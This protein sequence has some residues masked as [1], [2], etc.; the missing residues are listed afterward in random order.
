L[1]PAKVFSH[2]GNTADT[3]AN[4]R[5]NEPGNDNAVAEVIQRDRQTVDAS[6]PA[7]LVAVINWE[8]AVAAAKFGGF[9]DRTAPFPHS[10]H[11]RNVSVYCRHT[12]YLGFDATI[13]LNDQLA[14]AG[15]T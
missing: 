6:Y 15:L 12:T 11:R 4:Q 14:T 9:A 3:A 5:R 2:Q 13:T 1:A 10:K 8:F 7:G